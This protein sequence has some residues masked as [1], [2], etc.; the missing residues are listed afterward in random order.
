MLRSKLLFQLYHSVVNYVNPFC[1][2]SVL[3]G[4]SDPPT[5]ASVISG[6][7]NSDNDG[8]NA[9]DAASGFAPGGQHRSE[10]HNAG[11]NTLDWSLN[12]A[13]QTTSV[14]RPHAR[15]LER[16]NRSTTDVDQFS[17]GRRSEAAQHQQ[18]HDA[19]MSGMVRDSSPGGRS[20]LE[21]SSHACDSYE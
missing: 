7:E 19:T 20:L 8:E 13:R 4:H 6:G 11:V 1:F 17:S 21:V 5:A 16:K 18:G 10:G 12:N 15:E 3:L 14:R 9:L 2:G